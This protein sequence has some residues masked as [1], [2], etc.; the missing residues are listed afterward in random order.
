[1]LGGAQQ[2]APPRR[3]QIS[4]PQHPVRFISVYHQSFDNCCD[5]LGWI[6][7]FHQVQIDNYT[8]QVQF[9]NSSRL[10]IACGMNF[11][12]FQFSFYIMLSI[13]NRLQYIVLLSHYL[14]AFLC[15]CY[16][17]FDC[18]PSDLRI[19]TRRAKPMGSSDTSRTQTY[20]HCR[21]IHII[22]SS[23]TTGRRRCR[24][25]F[26]SATHSRTVADRNTTDVDTAGGGPPKAAT[27]R[28][29]HSLSIRFIQLRF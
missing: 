24:P 7:F 28:G 18:R 23:F 22:S 20:L 25:T 21:P 15:T 14:G 12:L 16:G 11:S 5:L 26:L 19:L 13:E 10:K 1:M 6:F 3:L 2:L 29:I 4:T 17:L 8:T 9:M 27:I